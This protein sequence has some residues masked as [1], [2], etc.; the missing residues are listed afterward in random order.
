MFTKLSL[1]PIQFDNRFC[2]IG[3]FAAHAEYPPWS[4][5]GQRQACVCRGCSLLLAVAQGSSQ[6]S[7]ISQL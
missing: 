6:L 4:R 7:R 1:L 2:I 3:L 5:Y